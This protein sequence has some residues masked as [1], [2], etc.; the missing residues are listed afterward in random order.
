MSACLKTFSLS[1]FHS[2]GTASLTAWELHGCELH[3]C[4][5][6]AVMQTCGCMAGHAAD[7]SPV[8]LSLMVHQLLLQV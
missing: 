7:T 1:L 3:I 2:N 8:S 6:T 5:F 4:N